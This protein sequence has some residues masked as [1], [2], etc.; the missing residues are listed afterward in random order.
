MTGSCGSLSWPIALTRIAVL[1]CSIPC[2]PS[3]V[4]FQRWVVS[5]H[6]ALVSAVE[7]CACSVTPYSLPMRRMYSFSSGCGAK[8]RDHRFGGA[9]ENE[10]AWF[11]VSTAQPG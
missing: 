3:S 9:N 4:T 7:N 2:G 5:S 6:V 1:V 8:N 10:Y 11:G